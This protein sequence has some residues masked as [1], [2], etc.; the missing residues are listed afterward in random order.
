MSG[1]VVLVS[2][3]PGVGKTTTARALAASGSRGAHLDTDGIGEDFIVAG[4]VLPGGNPPDE[5]ERQLTLRRENIWALTRNLVAAGFDVA[6]SDVVLWPS[7]LDDYRRALPVPFR[8]V[9]LTASAEEIS[10][11]DAHRDKHVAEDWTHLRA[12]Q[13]AWDSPGLRMDTT[14]LSLD[15]TLQAIRARWDDALV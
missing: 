1:S 10:H 7:L 6:V 13:D 3:L 11:R 12:D 9:L 4:L 15:E 14:G 8:F 2:G 5:A